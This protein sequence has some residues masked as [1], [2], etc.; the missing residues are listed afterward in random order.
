[1]VVHPQDDWVDIPPLDEF[2]VD[3][4]ENRKNGRRNRLLRVD[5]E[6][7]RFSEVERLFIKGWRHGKKDKPEVHFIFKVLWTEALLES[8][9]AYRASVQRTVK[10]KDK[11]GNERLLFH[12]TN[13]A[14]LLGETGNNVLLCSLRDCSLCSI[15]RT[16]F[17]VTKCGSKNA[18]KRFGHGIYTTSCSSKADDYTTNISKEATLRVALVSRVVVGIPYKRYRN[19]TD[20]VSPPNGYHS[21]AGEIGWDLNYEETVTYHND[22]IRPA[23]LVVYGNRQE[24]PVTLKTFVRSMFKTP[25]AS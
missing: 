2:C 4:T 9:L 14:C 20:L 10:A 11:R 21:I 8:Y 25:L 1:M 15:L 23:Y 6:N 3:K 13:R 22:T 16:S 18:F 24:A 12:G 5:R 17:D 19:A 7:P